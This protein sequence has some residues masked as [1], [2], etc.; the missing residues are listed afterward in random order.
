MLHR[1]EKKEE[2]KEKKLEKKKKKNRKLNAQGERTEIMNTPE[3][4]RR[5]AAIAAPSQGRQRA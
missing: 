5:R 3:W 1:Q 4:W 2:K